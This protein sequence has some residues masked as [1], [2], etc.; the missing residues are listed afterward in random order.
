MQEYVHLYPWL[1]ACRI[2]SRCAS[3][4]SPPR[5]S[6]FPNNL[7]IAPTAAVLVTPSPFFPLCCPRGQCLLSLTQYQ[8]RRER[9]GKQRRPSWAISI[10]GY[11]WGAHPPRDILIHYLGEDIIGEEGYPKPQSLWI[12]THASTSWGSHEYTEIG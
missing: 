10:M 11:S 8:T 5:R 9:R 3:S 7:I 2:A 6:L 4:A 1:P 12:I